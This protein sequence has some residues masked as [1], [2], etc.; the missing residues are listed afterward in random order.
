MLEIDRYDLY[1]K[2]AYLKHYQ[3]EYLPEFYRC[4]VMTGSLLVNSMLTESVKLTLVE[5]AGLSIIATTK[6]RAVLSSY[7]GLEL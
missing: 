6:L 2:V 7:L 3:S 1:G 5:L 4:V